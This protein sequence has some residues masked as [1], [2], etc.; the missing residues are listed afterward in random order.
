MIVYCNNLL[1][2]IGYTLNCHSGRFLRYRGYIYDGCLAR[3]CRYMYHIIDDSLRIL[4]DIIAKAGP[5]LSYQAN[6]IQYE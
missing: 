1:T 3:V 5:T 4:C 6:Q 2:R